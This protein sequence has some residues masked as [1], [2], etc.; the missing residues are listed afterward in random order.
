MSRIPTLGTRAGGI[1]AHVTSLPDGHGVGDLGPPARRFLD[2]LAGAGQR[3]WQMLPVGPAGEGFSPYSSTFAGDPV[4]ISLEDLL[5]D[6]LMSRGGIPA[7]R[8]RRAHRVDSPLVTGAKEV[9]LRR[10]FE[11]S[12]RMRSRRRF[13]DFCEANAAWLDDFAL[14]RILKRLHPGRP[15]YAWPEA[16]R[17]RNPATLDSLRTREREEA[18][19]V[20]FEQ[21]VFQL[22]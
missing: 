12:T 10:A 5:R 20:R 1:L 15:W 18:E 16:Q 7:K 19:F 6:G 21:F 14:F 11:R 22:Q 9:A 13:H 3:W 4:L 2:F 8:D 17:R